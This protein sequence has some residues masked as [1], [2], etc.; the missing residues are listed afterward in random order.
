VVPQL[1]AAHAPGVA[2]HALIAL[3]ALLPLGEAW[4]YWPRVVRAL[5]D[6]V[7]GTRS[8]AYRNL[9]VLEWAFAAAVVALWIAQHRAWAAL[10]VGA[11]RLLPTLLGAAF[12]AG[13]T[14]CRRS[15]T[16]LLADSTESVEKL[17]AYGIGDDRPPLRFPV[18]GT[19]HCAPC[20]ICC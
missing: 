11:G 16:P 4:W 14:P 8:R 9:I 15:G 20:V 13:F 2:D 12:V 7:P 5:A 6:R 17:L 19:H 10:H 18:I 1:P 3:L